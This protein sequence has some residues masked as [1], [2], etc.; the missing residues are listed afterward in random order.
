M[1][2]RDETGLKRT[3]SRLPKLLHP[4]GKFTLAELNEYVK[5]AHEGRRRLKEQLRR[6]NFSE[7]HKTSFSYT[8]L[9][10]ETEV[11]VRAPEAS[12][13]GSISQEAMAS[14]T[15]FTDL[16]GEDGKVGLFRFEVSVAPGTGKPKTPNSMA[17]PMTDD[18]TAHQQGAARDPARRRRREDGPRVLREGG[19]GGDEGGRKVIEHA[20]KRKGTS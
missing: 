2:G 18:G 4:D 20:A 15:V 19:P 10:D 7:F 9:T 12:I 17:R 14:G 3:V 13:T 16:V 5:L 6:R 11:Q 8:D 1:E